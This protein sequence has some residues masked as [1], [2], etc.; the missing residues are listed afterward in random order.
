MTR[1]TEVILAV[2]VLVL[3]ILVIGFLLLQ[4]KKAPVVQTNTPPPVV[5][6]TGVP[7]VPPANIPKNTT[8]SAGTVSKMFVERL[9]SYSSESDFVNID[10]IL[11]LATASFQ[12]SL[13]KIANDARAKAKA[14]DAYYGISTRVISQ[15]AK[16]ETDTTATMK[17]T[18]Q[19]SESI[20]SPGNTTVRYQDITVNLVKEG[21]TWKVSGFTWAE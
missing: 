3:L 17:L 5:T 18:T 16:E 21:T 10:D 20:G 19:R 6:G 9:G 15:S 2:S 12:N 11:S 8:V 13:K 14:D 4:G 1:K 7:E